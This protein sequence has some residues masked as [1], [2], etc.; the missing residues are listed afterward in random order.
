MSNPSILT[1]D[2]Y[3]GGLDRWVFDHA[4]DHNNLVAAAQ[5]HTSSVLKLY[6]LDPIGN[7]LSQWLLDHQ[8][9]HQDL[10]IIT[11][12]QT[13]DLQTVDLTDP[14]E[15]NAWLELNWQEHAAFAAVLGI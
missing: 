11:G 3:P 9:A 2:P 14:G 4:Q 5:P 8:Q 12:V 10:G 6:L 7:N 1:I 15:R 13:S